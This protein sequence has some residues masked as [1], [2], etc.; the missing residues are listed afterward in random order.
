MAM[1]GLRPR[2]LKG[3]APIKGDILKVF[4]ALLFS[5]VCRILCDRVLIHIRFI[6]VHRLEWQI[7]QTLMR[8]GL[9][10]GVSSGSML[11]VNA[12]YVEFCAALINALTTSLLLR[13]LNFRQ[14]KHHWPRPPIQRLH[15]IK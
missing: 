13:A 1:S 15:R 4:F 2:P 14:A 7:A 5:F 8:R 10:C 6:I 3:L 11:F 12:L 9:F